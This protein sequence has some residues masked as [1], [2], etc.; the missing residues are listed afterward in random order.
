MID[1][2]K[3]FDVYSD[4]FVC[5]DCEVEI[6][7]VDVNCFRFLVSI[8]VLEKFREVF[9]ELFGVAQECIFFNL[10]WSEKV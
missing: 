2:F 6:S 3:L 10:V 4:I 7:G 5:K 8:Q 1:I 9:C